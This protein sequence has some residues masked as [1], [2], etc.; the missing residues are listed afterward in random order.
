MRHPAS[1]AV[2]SDDEHRASDVID[3]ET[4]KWHVDALKKAGKDAAGG[5]HGAV[6]RW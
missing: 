5:F 3:D 6:F 2:V 1:T 4:R